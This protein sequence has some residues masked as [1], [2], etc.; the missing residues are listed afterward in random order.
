MRVYQRGYY[1]SG[2][3][4][5][6]SLSSG[7]RC[8]CGEEGGSG[9]GLR[10]RRYDGGRRWIMNWRDEV[11]WASAA[12]GLVLQPRTVVPLSWRVAA[13]LIG[14]CL[15]RGVGGRPS[16]A[17][18]AGSRYKQALGSLGGSLTR[19]GELRR[20]P[21]GWGWTRTTRCPC[22]AR[23]GTLEEGKWELWI[24]KGQVQLRFAPGGRV[25]ATKEQHGD[26]WQMQEPHDYTI[27]P[28]A[29]LSGVHGNGKG[30]FRYAPFG[31]S[32]GVRLIFRPHLWYVRYVGM[33]AGAG[34]ASR[35]GNTP[36]SW[37][38]VDSRCVGSMQVLVWGLVKR[39]T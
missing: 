34:A 19:L 21:W 1:T 26:G 16:T 6:P 24:K 35:G 29:R 2:P 7:V 14:S 5:T 11:V 25:L 12:A 13:Q 32:R 15:W 23:E 8:G 17:P 33:S 18:R 22:W 9:G 28:A 30:G 38:G 37:G 36:S 3:R 4:S 20:S 27:R 10:W 31:S 39:E